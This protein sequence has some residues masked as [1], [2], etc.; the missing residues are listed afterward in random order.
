MRRLISFAIG[1]TILIL[2]INSQSHSF[3]TILDTQINANWKWGVIS[4]IFFLVHGLIIFFAWGKSLS[5]YSIAIPT[6]E[7]APVHFI[8]LISR[9]LP[10][11]IWHIAGRL[12]ALKTKGFDIKNVLSTL[13]HE[14]LIAILSCF[15]LVLTF[16]WIEPSIYSDFISFSL[17]KWAALLTLVSL[18]LFLVPKLLTQS[19]NYFFKILKKKPSY[20]SS[21]TTVLLLV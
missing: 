3:S 9:Y 11:G 7:L 16:F 21:A 19:L 1:L 14:Q 17:N 20:D 12:V 18:F 13:Y 8:S 5:Y 6:K 10:G 2:V 15:F 4:F